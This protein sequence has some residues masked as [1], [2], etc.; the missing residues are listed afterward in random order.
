MSRE[1]GLPKSP[2]SHLS[3]FLSCPPSWLEKDERYS[4][5]TSGS[6]ARSDT[7]LSLLSVPIVGGATI[8]S[9]KEILALVLRGRQLASSRTE[10]TECT[11]CI[12]RS[13]DFNSDHLKSRRLSK[14]CVLGSMFYI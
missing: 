12:S 1:C 3:V 2:G 4:S 8:S 13:D 9:A 5:L 7:V 10:E 11:T 6:S 14:R